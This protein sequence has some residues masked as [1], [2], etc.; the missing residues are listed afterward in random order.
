MGLHDR[1]LPK[2]GSMSEKFCKLGADIFGRGWQTKLA[3]H[4][5]YSVKQINN[6][7]C[8]RNEAQ[9]VLMKYLRLMKKHNLLR[10]KYLR[11]LKK[12]GK[13]KGVK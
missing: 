2:G 3:K 10:I 7:A 13:I 6:I 8:G 4:C 1:A 9:L 5:G 11:L 12:H